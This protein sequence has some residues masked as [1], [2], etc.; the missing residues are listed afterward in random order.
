LFLDKT[1]GIFLKSYL[2]KDHNQLLK[3]LVII[4][5]LFFLSSVMTLP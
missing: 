3:V 4:A 5:A 2:L 1:L